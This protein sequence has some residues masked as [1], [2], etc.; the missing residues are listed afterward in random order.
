MRHLILSLLLLTASLASAQG[1]NINVGGLPIRSGAT[2]PSSCSTPGSLFFKTSTTRNWYFC[3]AGTFVAFVSG[4]GTVAWGS[5][6]GTLSS[7]T[8]LQ[9][10]LDLKAPLASPALTGTPTAPTPSAA[11]NSTKI[12]TTAYVD[13]ADALKAN[14]ASPTLTGT[15]LAP[16]PGANTN[17]TQIPT[18]AWVLGQ[19]TPLTYTWPT[20]QGVVPANATT[21]ISNTAN[22]ATIQGFWHPFPQVTTKI[23]YEVGTTADNTAATY[24]FGIYTGTSGGAGTLIANIGATAGTTAVPTANTI[25]C[26]NWT[27]GTVTIPAGR[28]YLATTTSQAGTA[29]TLFGG[30][31]GATAINGLNQFSISAGGTLSA[32]TLPTDGNATTLMVSATVMWFVIQ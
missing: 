30:A 32:V 25:I 20:F 7:Q 29:A 18:T 24:D 4:S 27:Q 13:T 14:L 21:I 5:I 1:W 17:T 11:D 26:R 19:I 8:D 2:V 6:T 28:I 16:T 15:P 12:A 23:C 10:A 3:Q 22:K 9:A 31:V